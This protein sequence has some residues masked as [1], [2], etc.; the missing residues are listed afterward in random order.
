MLIHPEKQDLGESAPPLAAGL[1]P[2]EEK[3]R[4]A[5]IV[6]IRAE[7]IALSDQLRAERAE[8][9]NERLKQMIERQQDL[10]VTTRKELLK[11]EE[12][13]RTIYRSHFW[14]WSYPVRRLLCGLRIDKG[15]KRDRFL[16]RDKDPLSA[17]F[18][19]QEAVGDK[20]A[21]PLGAGAR[22]VLEDLERR[23]KA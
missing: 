22:Q 5:E 10:L 21:P 1:I 19:V 12:H 2:P 20:S 9:E 7:K 17:R 14:R 15:I 18:Q 11:M 23:R 13:F 4:L 6:A 16:E 3:A 8:E